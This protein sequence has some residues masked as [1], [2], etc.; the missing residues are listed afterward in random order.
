MWSFQNWRVTIDYS[1]SSKS[2]FRNELFQ[3]L[4]VVEYGADMFFRIDWMWIKKQ[5]Q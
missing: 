2:T 4:P 1:F 3:M 5:I